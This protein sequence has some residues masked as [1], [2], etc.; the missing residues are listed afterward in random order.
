MSV[1]PTSVLRALT[2]VTKECMNSRCW[3]SPS[4]AL[5]MEPTARSAS[6]E[7]STASICAGGTCSVCRVQCGASRRRRLMSGGRKTSSPMSVMHSVKARCAVAGSNRASDSTCWRR[8]VIM[9]ST[10]STRPWALRVGT[11]PAAVLTNS[12][13]SKNSRRRLSAWLMALWLSERPWAARVTLRSRTRASNTASRFR[14]RSPICTAFIPH[15]HCMLFT[16]NG[17]LPMLASS[18]HPQER[19]PPGDKPMTP[20]TKPPPS[21]A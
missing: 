20:T 12:G 15:M 21:S 4:G 16:N 1:S 8:M 5:R 14:S 17:P 10:G 2:M 6:P 3:N 19:I 18:V 13:S 11:M 9:P 7:A